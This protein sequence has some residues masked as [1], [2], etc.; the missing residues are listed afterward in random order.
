MMSAPQAALVSAI[1][2]MD[3]ARAQP[4]STEREQAEAVA[5][6]LEGEALY[7]VNRSADAAPV[8]ASALKQAEAV[9]SGTKLQGDLLKARGS[10]EAAQGRVQP[11]LLDFQQ[12]FR[13]YQRA[14]VT[15]GQAMMLQ[16]IGAIYSD[17]HDYEHTI[18]YYRQSSE[19]Y[20]GDPALT[21]TAHNNIGEVYLGLHNDDQALKEFTLALKDARGMNSAAMMVRVLPN[22][23]EAQARKGKWIEAKA[24]LAEALKVAA[25]DSSAKPWTPFIQGEVAEVELK[26]GGLPEARAAIE[27]AFAGQDLTRTQA[28]FRE[29]HKTAW[30]VYAALGDPAHALAHLLAFK[31][32][33]DQQRE[34]AASTDAALIGARFDFANQDLKIARLRA[35]KLQKDIVMA[36]ARSRAQN[37]LLG[38]VLG[39]GGVFIVLVFASF[40]TMRRSRDAVRTA[41]SRLENTN[42]ALERALKAKSQFLATTSHEIRTPLNGILGMAQVL[43]ADSSISEAVR[44][45]VEV[46]HSAGET[47]RALVDDILDLA[48]MERG[49]TSVDKR[50]MNLP[51]LLEGTIQLWRAQSEAKGVSLLLDAPNLPTT[52][53]ED[54]N[55]LRQVLFNLMS[56]AIKFTD[57]GGVTLRVLLQGEGIAFAVSD[58]GLGIALE[59]QERVF[60]PFIQVEGG[61]T[62]RHGG[63]GLG[64]AICRDV[65]RAL[66][67]DIKLESRPGQG[68]VFTVHLPLQQAQ[69]A[70]PLEIA[71]PGVRSSQMTLA[72]SRVMVVEP[73][74]LAR[75]VLSHS[76]K[77]EFA[78]VTTVD[79]L[80]AGLTLLSQERFDQVLVAGEA[81]GSD[82]MSASDAASVIAAAAAAPVSVLLTQASSDLTVMLSATPIWQLL[83]RPITSQALVTALSRPHPSV[84][85]EIETRA[86]A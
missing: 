6:W 56:N 11:A 74:P 75:A 7:R 49:S 45:R 21:L 25:S 77:A 20:S 67:G 12:A 23:A 2:A 82:I 26:R 61:T 79:S 33:D 80:D 86:A 64:L 53:I 10:V 24:S 38:T 19:L 54:E 22:L 83:E 84:P 60:E 43:L 69:T 70:A 63:T 14:G 73:N 46:V 65:T 1:A 48:K 3:F 8:I 28:E 30:Q 41:N 4:T 34:L 27:R 36:H 29:D 13:V 44:G 16:D 37:T 42:S 18:S 32:L 78:A 68:S 72:D 76:L 52:I 58:S 50:P 17:A 31:R 81:L 66:G 71:T 35:E 15:R 62:R 9:A 55:R 47:M 5:G 85:P 40:V 51:H 39:A 57:R 59:D